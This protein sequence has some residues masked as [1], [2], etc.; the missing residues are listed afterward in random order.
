MRG[1]V[2]LADFDGRIGFPGQLRLVDLQIDRLEHLAVG[3]SLF[4]VFEEQDVPDDEFAFRN[5]AEFTVADH[6]DRRIVADLVQNVELL[7]GAEF[8]QEGQAG[9]QQHRDDDA[10]SFDQAAG[11][12]RDQGG[13]DQNP[14]HRVVEFG[15]ELFVP[16][17]P[18]GG[19]QQVFAVQA[20]AVFHFGGGQAAVTDGGTT[21]FFTHEFP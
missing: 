20:A 21:V 18:F 17:F 7:F 8:V 16:R 15:E 12:R 13:D 14:D 9:R 19:S 3:G 10:G 2:R 4:A 6:L 1:G 5:L 11:R